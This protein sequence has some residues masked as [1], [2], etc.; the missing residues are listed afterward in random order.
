MLS[1]RF[2]MRN[3]LMIITLI[4]FSMMSV[5]VPA[6]TEDDPF[7][8]GE[9]LMVDFINQLHA[10]PEGTAASFD[11]DPAAVRKVLAV[12]DDTAVEPISA[13]ASNAILQWAAAERMDDLLQECCYASEGAD[14]RS[15]S[16]RFADAGYMAIDTGELTGIV[17]FANF[18]E[19]DTA[20]RILFKEMLR[21]ELAIEETESP[22]LLNGAFED[23]GV[24]L[25]SGTVTL[26]RHTYNVYAAVCHFGTRPDEAEREFLNLV[27]QARVSPLAVATARGVDAAGLVM[28]RPDL[29]NIFEEGLPPVTFDARLYEAARGHTEDM[30]EH[31]Y[32]GHDSWDGRT[33]EDRLWNA[34]YTAIDAE[35]A[36]DKACHCVC[37]E[38]KDRAEQFFNRLFMQEMGAGTV[39]EDMMILGGAF[40]DAGTAMRAGI[41][42]DLGG[43]CGD[44]VVLFTTAFGA[45]EVRP[46]SV[47]HLSGVVY[48]DVNENGLYDAGEGDNAAV[49][50]TDTAGTVDTVYSDETGYFTFPCES[51]D[52]AIS[53]QTADG[54]AVQPQAVT[55]SG[56][57]V[58][59][60][61]SVPALPEEGDDADNM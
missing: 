44:E 36:V 51:G 45:E 55:V 15:L 53:V 58:Q 37:V 5:C 8:A 29:I 23:V 16:R 52:Y 28:D 33:F 14:D 13:V 7:A 22:A 48:R 12:E 40:T 2:T 20:V 10:D 3:V 59:I 50:V 46:D 54:G 41:N 21:K 27:N 6:Q 43:I 35:E 11:L 17:A 32:V 39:P 60:F 19:P 26:E 49:T 9:S 4:A 61:V 25:G 42:A 38:P 47:S 31:G 18:I 57:R 30:L 24:A 34:G 56:D 1:L